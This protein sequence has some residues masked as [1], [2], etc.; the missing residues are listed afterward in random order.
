MVTKVFRCFHTNV[1]E[2]E[3]PK[4]EFPKPEVLKPEVLE[5]GHSLKSL[6]HLGPEPIAPGCFHLSL[7]TGTGTFMLNKHGRHKKLVC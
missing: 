3:V 1:P 7:S 4:P 2:L 6:G 5:P